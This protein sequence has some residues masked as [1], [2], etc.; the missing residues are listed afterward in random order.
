MRKRI[1]L[2]ALL[3]AAAASGASATSHSA[4]AFK[5]LQALAGEW[6]GTDDKHQPV[7]TNF[8]SIV[9]NTAMMETLSPTGM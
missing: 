4:A 7:K 5:R 6:D 2:F 3:V 9:S 8:K 1:S